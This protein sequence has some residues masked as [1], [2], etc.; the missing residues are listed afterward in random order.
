MTTPLTSA[1]RDAIRAAPF[2][3]A[4]LARAAGMQPHWLTDI[5]HGRR[6]SSWRSVLRPRLTRGTCGETAEKRRTEKGEA[7][8]LTP[9]CLTFPSWSGKVRYPQQTWTFCCSCHSAE[10]SKPWLQLPYWFALYSPCSHHLSEKINAIDRHRM[11]VDYITKDGE[12]STAKHNIKWPA[13][14]RNAIY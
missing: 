11:H 7:N 1:L 8:C 9:L 12:Q 2:S 14:S 10:S 4:K 6:M 13:I 5:F 3:Q